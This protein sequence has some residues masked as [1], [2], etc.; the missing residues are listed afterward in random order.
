MYE[1]EDTVQDLDFA[2]KQQ[3]AEA[4]KQ[5]LKSYKIQSDLDRRLLLG[6]WDSM[7]RDYS[8]LQKDLSQSKI[9]LNHFNN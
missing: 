4:T 3:D 6:I 1:H 7:E 5:S 9:E 8:T 2:E